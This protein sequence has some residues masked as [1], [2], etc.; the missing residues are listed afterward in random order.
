LISKVRPVQGLAWLARLVAY[1][2]PGL[3]FNS[4]GSKIH[5]ILEKQWKYGKFSSGI[6]ISEIK[7]IIN[8]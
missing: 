7:E 5:H 4:L 8:D 6:F 3:K 1:Y 2:A